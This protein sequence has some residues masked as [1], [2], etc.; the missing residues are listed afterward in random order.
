MIAGGDVG[1]K[2]AAANKARNTVERLSDPDCARESLQAATQE[3]EQSVSSE[4]ATQV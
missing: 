2:E 4:E 1:V 3:S